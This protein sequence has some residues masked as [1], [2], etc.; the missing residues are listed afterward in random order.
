MFWT[1]LYVT[2]CS[3]TNRLRRRLQRLRE[4]RYLIGLIVGAVYFYLM[5]F[6]RGARG[7]RG[8][9]GAAAMA[10]LAGPVQLIGSLFL[11][12]TAAIAWAVPGAGKPIAF[13]RPEV[14]FFFTAPVTRRELLHYKLLRSQIGILISSAITTLVLRPGS[15]GGTWML[16]VG[17]WT[18]LM[19][20]RLHLMGVALTRSSL[21]QHGRSTPLLQWL[22]LAAVLGAVGALTAQ[23]AAA[24]PALSAMPDGGAVLDE[25]QRLSLTG[26]AAVVLWPFRALVGRTCCRS[27][28]AV[29]ALPRRRGN[30][31]R[32]RRLC[33]AAT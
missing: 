20:V 11:L 13:T 9:A 29:A 7:P 28:L 21:V 16:L 25:I 1:F 6:R 10:Q 31:A 17:L 8:P 2:R 3:T 22:P 30:A 5:F 33:R 18:V 23:V 4:P 26:A 32:P 14:Q 24:W 12:V 19:A 15:L 27:E